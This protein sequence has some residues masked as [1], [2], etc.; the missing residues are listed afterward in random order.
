MAGNRDRLRSMSKKNVQ[1]VEKVKDVP[2]LISDVA[3]RIE[4]EPE[5]KAVDVKD[6]FTKE[7]NVIQKSDEIDVHKNQ[8]EEEV[9]KEPQLR[10][11]ENREEISG[12]IND[13]SE[14]TNLPADEKKEDA[15]ENVRVEPEK[16][17]TGENSNVSQAVSEN[18]QEEKTTENLQVEKTTDLQKGWDDKVKE[19]NEKYQG[20]EVIVSLLLRPEA[21]NYLTYKAMDLRISGKQLL[22]NLLMKELVKGYSEDDL[23]PEFRTTQRQTVKKSVVIDKQ[24]KEDIMEAAIKYRMKYTVFIHYIIYRAYLNDTDYKELM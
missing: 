5:D 15:K 17:N 4:E 7:E 23:C 18:V 19:L 10:K 2:T 14:I 9:P 8:V 22:K 3:D 24:L 6:E 13:P 16:L 11:D 1:E 12:L 21:S 20:Q